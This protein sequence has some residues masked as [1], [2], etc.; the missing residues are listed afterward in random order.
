MKSFFMVITLHN[1]HIYSIILPYSTAHLT[2][3]TI[4][5]AVGH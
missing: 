3:Q 4:F 1:L 5:T 2:T